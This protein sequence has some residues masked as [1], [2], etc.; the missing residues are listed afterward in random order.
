MQTSN[1]GI[2]SLAVKQLAE[3]LKISAMNTDGARVS[4]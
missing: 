3:L 2:E 1:V 4:E